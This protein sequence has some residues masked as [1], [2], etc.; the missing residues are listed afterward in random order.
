[1]V[2]FSHKI[3]L[4]ADDMDDFKKEDEGDASKT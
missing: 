4:K 2:I 3:A 1:M